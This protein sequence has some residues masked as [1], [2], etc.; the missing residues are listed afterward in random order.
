MATKGGQRDTN[1]KGRSQ[2]S[3][4]AEVVIVYI[5]DTKNITREHL[6]AHKQLQQSGY[7]QN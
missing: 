7:V 6:T 1:R 4:F 3:L 2:I 5:S